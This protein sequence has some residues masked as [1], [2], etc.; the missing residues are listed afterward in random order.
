M[1]VDLA[2]VEQRIQA[3]LEVLN[4]WASDR[5][6]SPLSVARQTVRGWLRK[7]AGEG[8]GGWPI[9]ASRPL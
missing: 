8:M 6:R 7:Y 2:R 4:D 3:V 9:A 1:L 5:R